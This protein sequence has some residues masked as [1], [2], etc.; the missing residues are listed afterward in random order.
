MNDVDGGLVLIIVRFIAYGTCGTL[1]L[2]AFFRKNHLQFSDSTIIGHTL[3]F[4]GKRTLDIYL[5]HYFFLPKNLA[6]LGEF[7]S[8]NSNPTVELFFSLIITGMVIAMS[9]LVSEIIRL[10]P[11][12]ARLMLGV[13]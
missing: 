6:M 13:R 2:F 7:F 11:L 10:S 8:A 9:L 3:Q 4:I 1:V 12:L 5:I